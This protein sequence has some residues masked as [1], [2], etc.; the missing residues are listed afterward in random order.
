MSETV[1]AEIPA[2]RYTAELAGEIEVRWQDYWDEHGTFYAPNPTGP[3]ADPEHP[4][5]P[6]GGD[7]KKLFVLDMFPYPSGAGLH[8]GHP[9]GYIGTDC[10]ARYSRMA[11]YNVLHAMGFDAFGL[12]AEQYAVETGT[13]PRVTTEANI[14]KYRAQLHRLGL[15]YDP[16]RSVAT[17]DVEFYRWTQWIFLQVFNSWF[18]PD[19]EEGP[20][21]R[22]AGRGVRIRPAGDTG[23][24]G[25][26]DAVRCRAPHDH[27]RPP[28]GVRQRGAGQLVPRPGHGAGRRRGDRGRALGS[29]QLPGVQADHEAVADA[30]HRVRRPAA[31]RP[32]P[33]G[34]AGAGQDDA[35]QL[36][37]PLDRRAHRLRHGRR[38]ADPGVHDPPGHAVR[39]DLHGAGARA[40]VGRR[41]GAGA[42][43]DGTRD[44]WT[45]GHA[46]P[47]EAVAAYRAFTNSQVPRSSARPTRRRRPASSSARTRR[48]R[49]TVA[50]SRCSS[51][52]TCWPATAPAR[53][54]RCPVRTSGTGRSP[55]RSICRSSGRSSRRPGSTV[56]RTPARARRST[57]ATPPRASTWTAWASPTR[58]RA[59]SSW[60]EQRGHGA[61][62][63][64]L[65]AA[66]L[67][68][69]PAALL[70]RAV[71]DRLRRDRPAGRAARVDAAGRAAG[72]GRLRA[73]AAR[74]QR[75]RIR[76]G[77]AA[78]PCDRLGHRRAGS[79]RRSARPIPAR[80]T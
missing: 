15:G 52:T 56:R 44:A 64:H 58:R 32:G 17:T 37:R 41:A 7:A 25:L 76:A 36:D 57:A 18:D 4:R 16:R 80:R 40:R 72:A 78:V 42:W 66:R 63:G 11:G 21:D 34:L 22:G 33:A 69:Q 28:A 19:D 53:S 67:A 65:P 60:L 75:R 31:G 38:H 46:T 35:A 59:S 29:R 49:S 3:L 55:R 20:A 74:H 10:F 27:R 30:H 43:P 61:G 68:V 8:V 24:P 51:P 77:D 13:H 5:S 71:P 1:D 45:G 23:R 48:T 73:E 6:A 54:W 39:R 79:G 50:R 70:G 9:L 14:E 12:P 62:R 47:A 2:Y 26:V